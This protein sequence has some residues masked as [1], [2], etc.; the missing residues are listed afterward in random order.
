VNR[1]VQ[2]F[3]LLFGVSSVGGCLPKL[4]E[5]YRFSSETHTF[6]RTCGDLLDMP[7]TTSPEAVMRRLE[8][9][10]EGMA[11]VDTD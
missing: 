10:L 1:V 9:I 7:E 2:H 4:N 6:L 3:Q 5:V 8:G 11:D